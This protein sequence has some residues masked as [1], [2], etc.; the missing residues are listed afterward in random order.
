MP[1]EFT[2]SLM[3]VSHRLTQ[4]PT[5]EDA[6]WGLNCVAPPANYLKPNTQNNVVLF[7]S[8]PYFPWVTSKPKQHETPAALSWNWGLGF[9][10]LVF[11]FR[12]QGA[13]MG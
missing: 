11:G 3:I 7:S 12:V 10:F 5:I 13:N 6:A 1:A 2:H 9:R 4:F 8:P